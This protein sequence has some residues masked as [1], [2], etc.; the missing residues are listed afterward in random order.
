MTDTNHAR[1]QAEAQLEHIR[2]LVEWL[3]HANECG[4]NPNCLMQY[5][6]ASD[7]N[8]ST[9]D[10]DAA[11][12]AIH[13]HPLSIEIRG[14][15]HDVGE[16]QPMNAQAEEFRILLS[17]G[18]PACRIVGELNEHCEPES[19]RIEYQDWGTPWTEY[20]QYVDEEG[21]LL[22]YCQQFYFCG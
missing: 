10:S 12:Q 19:A 11:Q 9:H 18:G 7:Y 6:I 16:Y 1:Q 3:D 4:S 20:Y 2:T 13:E 22:R 21:A 14:G 8:A 5:E 15:W 17:T